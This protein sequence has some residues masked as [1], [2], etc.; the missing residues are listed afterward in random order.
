M[1]VA[2][3]G[4][5]IKGV[6]TMS[7]DLTELQ[8]CPDRYYVIVSGDKEFKEDEFFITAFDDTVYPAP[9]QTILDAVLHKLLCNVVEQYDDICL[10]V[11]DNCGADRLALDWALQHD[12]D[13][14]FYE[15]DW[16]NDGKAAGFK[17]NE[18]MF[19]FAARKDHRATIIFWDG[20]NY[21]TRNLIYM[22]VEYKIP[23]RVYNYKQKRMLTKLEIEGIFNLEK[24][25]KLKA[26]RSKKDE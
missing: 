5:I 24:E 26:R 15:A 17:R 8:K 11:G 3:N 19:C 9:A 6:T 14:R 2:L 4:Y 20:D 1:V 22:G 21:M 7:I 25:N 23:M 18:N 12:Y 13:V 10:I 16:D